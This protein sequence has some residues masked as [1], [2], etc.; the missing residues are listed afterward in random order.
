[1]SGH[2]AVQFGDPD[3]LETRGEGSIGITEKFLI[4]LLAWPQAGELDLG[5]AQG[6]AGVLDQI[7][8]LL[9]PERGDGTNEMRA[10]A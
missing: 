2:H 4:E 9:L 3:P 5:L 1:M 7:D 10:A 8:Q 6:G